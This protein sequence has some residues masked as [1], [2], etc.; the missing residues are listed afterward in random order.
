M[1]GYVSVTPTGLVPQW[2]DAGAMFGMS[3]DLIKQTE[4][5]IKTI[6]TLT[7]GLFPPVINPNFPSI[8][9]P[10]K[11]ITATAPTLIDVKWQTPSTPGPFAGTVDISKYMPSPFTG[12]QPTLNFGSPPKQFAANIPASPAIDL[13]FTYPTVLLTLPNA[14]TLM[15]LTQVNFN[16]LDIPTFDKTV[17]ELK[18]S[19]P[20]PI[21]YVEKA[22]YTSTTLTDIQNSLQKALTDDTDTGLTAETQQALWDAAREREYRQQAAG[23]MELERMEALGYAFPPGVYIDARIKLQTETN[24]TLAGLSR[25]IMVKQADLHLQNVMKSRELAVTLEGQLITYYNAIAQRSFEAARYITEASVQIY[26]AQVQA[27]AAQL[28]GFKAQVQ[29][30][31]AQIRGIE[32]QIAQTRARIDFERTKAEINTALVGQYKAEI[33]AALSYL[34]IY[35]TQV[36]IIQIRAGVEKTKVD[37]FSAQ[38]Q[39][40]VGQVNAYTAEV[41]G[42]KA[43]V[44]TQGAIEN[45]YRTQVEAY[46]AQVQAGV[47]AANALV[48]QFRGQVEAYTA[49]LDGYKASLQAMVSQAQ[50]AQMFNTA[51][52]DAYRALTQADAAYNETLTKQWEAII[53]EQLQVTQVAVKAAEAN[54]QLYISVRQLSLDAAK[55]GAQVAAQLGAAA[56]SAIHWQNSSNWSLSGSNSSAVSTSNST[57]ENHNYNATV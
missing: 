52:V 20:S 3:Q 4:A 10:P 21:P 36:Q 39:A 30:Y 42:Y 7:A 12:A 31:E 51:N 15:T 8:S 55:V 38:I 6:G 45:V 16:P 54:A 22:F 35:K 14:P 26:N 37:V 17:P 48:A 46:T 18:I 28:E 29:A 50:S 32:A 34:E 5:Y 24:N 43:Q 13:N 2:G 41:E 53:N 56:L 33:D 27:Y 57:S 25:D 1:S 40:Y 44:E 47:A 19:P 23:L 11:P 49:Q 9:A